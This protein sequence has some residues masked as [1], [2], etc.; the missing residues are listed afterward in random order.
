MISRS[1][2]LLERP[3]GPAAR[4]G[5]RG[6]ALPEHTNY[7]DTGCDLY[8]SCLQ[9]PLPR[10]RYEEPGGAAAILR[11]GRD[12]SILRLAKNSR[13]GVDEL[14]R[15][16]GVSRRTIFRVLSTAKQYGDGELQ[17]TSP[18]DI[19]D[20]VSEFDAEFAAAWRQHYAEVRSGSDAAKDA[21]V[22]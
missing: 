2:L 22:N 13:L 1:A 20:M 11:Q 15:S 18:D 19:A 4:G 21:R 3:L 6:N 12:E 16:F 8:P 7:A 17:L 5:L 10:C 9:C 14:A